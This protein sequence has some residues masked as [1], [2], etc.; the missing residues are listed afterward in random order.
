M[1]QAAQPA[2]LDAEE[3]LHLAVLDSQAG[4]HDVA[5]AKLKLA[6][7]QAPDNAKVHYLL[8]AEH[9]EIGLFDRAIEG[10]KKAVSLGG[11]PDTVHLQLGLLYFTQG[12]GK[13][14]EAAW[15]QLDRLGP[16]DALFL[17]K[18]GLLKVDAGDAAGAVPLLERAAQNVRGN[19]ALAKD[20]GRVLGNIRA[21]AAA[22]PAAA[23]AGAAVAP[24]KPA[25]HLLATKYADSGNDDR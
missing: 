4:R 1:S 6:A 20:I 25:A 3:L 13:E 7:E 9:A 16:D 10:M 5:I 21:A 22:G 23:K 15:A 12:R 14:A 19:A 8:A 24:A 18:S 17:F 11:A 2:I